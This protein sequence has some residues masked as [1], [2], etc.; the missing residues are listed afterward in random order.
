MSRAPKRKWVA[1]PWLTGAFAAEWVP[2]GSGDR[3][4]IGATEV[5]FLLVQFLPGDAL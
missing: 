3:I 2:L 1:C 4:V 5:V